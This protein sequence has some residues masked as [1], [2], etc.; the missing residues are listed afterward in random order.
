MKKLDYLFSLL[1]GILLILSFPNFDLEFLAWFA[2]V[3]LFYAV[4]G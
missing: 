4:E 3:P 2:F 1:S